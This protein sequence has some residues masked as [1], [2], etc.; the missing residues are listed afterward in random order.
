MTL[1]ELFKTRTVSRSMNWDW[2]MVASHFVIS[3]SVFAAMIIVG[4]LW[5][6]LVVLVCCDA[7]RKQ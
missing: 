3:D 2:V 1:S 7:P 6:S 4:W 5:W